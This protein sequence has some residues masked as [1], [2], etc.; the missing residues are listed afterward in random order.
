M[1]G[2]K[3]NGSNVHGM[4]KYSGVVKK[5]TRFLVCIVSSIIA[6]LTVVYTLSELQ[7]VWYMRENH[8]VYRSD[9]G[10]DLGF[11]LLGLLLV[12]AF[13]ICLSISSFII[14]KLLKKFNVL[15]E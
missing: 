13:I 7:V 3:D 12:P 14:W 6:S 5:I 4:S 1:K 2:K 11:G 8:I 15:S 10:N 9:L